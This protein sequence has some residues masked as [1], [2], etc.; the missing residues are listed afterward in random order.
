MLEETEIRRRVAAARVARLATVDPAG[1]PHLVPICFVLDG[2]VLYSAVDE[3]PKRSP[4]LKRLANVRANPAATVLVDAYDE[5]WSR[6][7]W[8][9][10]DGRA[11]VLEERA[12]RER[13]LA[14]LAGKYPQY[15]AQRPR[16]PVLALTIGGW[17]SWAAADQQS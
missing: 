14:L 16:G 6:L 9:R 1:Q 5:D 3:K 15:R 4:R 8:V 11:R 17:R 7:W 13:A 2:D 12:E 10:L